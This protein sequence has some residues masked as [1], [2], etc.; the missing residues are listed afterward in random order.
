MHAHSLPI[1]QV[2]SLGGTIAMTSS[3]DGAGVVPKLSGKALVAAVPESSQVAAVSAASFLTVPG[4]HLTFGDLLALANR[5]D[6]VLAG[7]AAG[8][9]V[10]QGTDTIE[11]TAFA[12]DLLVQSDKPVVVTGAMRNPTVPGADGPANLLAAV[13]AAA[14]P[15]L[16][17]MGTVVVLNDEMHGARFV[18]K[19][20]TIRC[21][22]FHSPNAGPVGWVAEGRVRVALRLPPGPKVL[23]GQ[24]S[25]EY[26]EAPVALY[27]VALGDDG[28]LLPTIADAGYRGLVVEATG[29][30]HVSPPVADRLGELAQRMPVVLST[31]TNAGESLRATYGFVG[32]ETDL[33]ERGLIS[34]GLLDGPKSRVLL[35]LLLGLE[36][37]S[38][39]RIVAAFESYFSSQSQFSF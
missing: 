23:C 2:L 39:E 21:D 38:R 36:K 35:T 10:T 26:E 14:S 12:L 32:S 37:P 5:I 7:E 19:G 13:S 28:R 9:V 25:G 3:D 27:S 22:A 16:T 24:F 31:R 6:Q 17:G 4:A 15:A 34:A 8:V 20:H 1:V 18:R 11:E 33:L 29:G 30:G